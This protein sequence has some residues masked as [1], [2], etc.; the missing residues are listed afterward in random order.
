MSRW[1]LSVIADSGFLLLVWIVH[2]SQLL[3]VSFDLVLQVENFLQQEA[4][5]ARLGG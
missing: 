4:G 5:D 1:P 2:R 3:V